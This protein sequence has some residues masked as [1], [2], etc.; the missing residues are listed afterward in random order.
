M[1]KKMKS[2]N[3]FYSIQ[4]KDDSAEISIFDEVGFWGTSA[5]Q[6]KN[7]WNDIKDKKDI[8]LLLNSP[9]GDVFAGIAI[10]NLVAS[11]RDN[12]SVE[13]LG[14]AASAASIVALAG[15]D[16]IMREGSFFMIHN[17]WGI[18]IGDKNDMAK[19]SND[20]E[21][22]GGEIARIYEKH[23][24]LNLDEVT[25]AMDEETWYTAEEAE[26]AGFVNEI[27]ENETVKNK[28]D[29]SDYAHVPDGMSEDVKN[30]EE[31]LT[32]RDA[33]AALRDAGFSR[34]EAKEILS[35]GFNQREAEEPEETDDTDSGN[36]A[37]CNTILIL[38]ES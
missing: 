5:E 30:Q 23:S 38:T 28:F 1:K 37:A 33:E 25:A 21:K 19:M 36:V 13:I 27:I 12:V 7:E 31:D 11:K 4:A 16:L 6:F 34:N 20:L 9:G 3:K 22:I 32:I 18:S 10:Y 35:Q 2:R 8:R 29:L 17:P 26:E 14:V 24:A 15:K